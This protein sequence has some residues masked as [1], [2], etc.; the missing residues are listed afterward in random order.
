MINIE[1]ESEPKKRSIGVKSNWR[2]TVI[3]TDDMMPLDGKLMP[4]MMS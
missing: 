1:T 2:K 4:L 3:F